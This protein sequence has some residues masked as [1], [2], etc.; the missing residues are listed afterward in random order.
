MALGVSIE[1]EGKNIFCTTEKIVGAK[2]ELESPSV[3]ATEN[4]MLA[5]VLGEG[6]TVISNAAKEPEICDLEKC[7]NKMG[8]KISGCG[9][10]V[11]KILGVKKLKELSYHIMPDRIEAGTL[12]CAAAVTKGEI[13]LKDVIPEHLT[14]I[15]QKLKE[16]GCKL[17]I[18]KTNIKLKAPR[19][20][21]A[22]EIETMPYPGFPTDMQSIFSCMLSVAKKNS[23]VIENIFKNRY[24]YASELNKMGAK[25]E[26]EGNCAKIIGVRRLKGCDVLATDLR[27]GAGLII[28]GLVA[29]GETTVNNGEHILRGY[30]NLDKKLNSLGARITRG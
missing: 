25:I 12:L 7:L 16:S 6:E 19:K 10:G 21:K 5:A 15:L 20:L 18:E 30:E 23:F 14:P 28:A 27:G 2:I 11:I 1:E 24:K 4:I 13:T 26:A 17:D 29:A 22:V 9:T 8:A 3:G